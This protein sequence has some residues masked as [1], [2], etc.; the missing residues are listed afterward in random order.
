MLRCVLSVTL[1]ESVES[2]RFEDGCPYSINRLVLKLS[3]GGRLTRYAVCVN[4]CW[5]SSKD[6][7]FTLHEARQKVEE[8]RKLHKRFRRFTVEDLRGYAKQHGNMAAHDLL[9][10][11]G[12]GCLE[13]TCRDYDELL[14]EFQSG[15]GEHGNGSAE[16]GNVEI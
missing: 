11:G 14:K 6:E 15:V 8:L 16:T 9:L 12:Y 1:A 4:N 13:G 5:K 3:D 2:G 10:L 7:E